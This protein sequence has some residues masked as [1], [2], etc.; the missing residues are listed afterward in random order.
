MMTIAITKNLKGEFVIEAEGK[1][2]FNF[3]RFIKPQWLLVWE[4]LSDKNG[5]TCEDCMG[6]N[7]REFDKDSLSELGIWQDLDEGIKK[8]V[9]ARVVGQQSPHSIMEKAR[10]G[11]RKKYENI[12]RE[13]VCIKCKAKSSIP[14]GT[15]AKRI[16]KKDV[17]IEAYVAQF[18]CQ[19]CNFTKG[20]KPNPALAGLPKEITCKKCGKKMACSPSYIAGRAKAKNITTEEFIEGW[21]CQSCN[22]T[23]GR[24]KK[25][26]V[27][28]DETKVKSKARKDA[29]VAGRKARKNKVVSP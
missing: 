9:E 14:P 17:T 21:V 6:L 4:K 23:K 5:E 18:Q 26:D 1:R 15:L 10:A 28:K 12:P 29:I 20:R 13:L 3:V 2:K 22:N 25:T 27:E 24:R 19:A 11:R 16:E 7:V 8:E